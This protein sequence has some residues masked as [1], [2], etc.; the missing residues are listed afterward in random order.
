MRLCAGL[1]V[2]IEGDIHTVT[3]QEELVRWEMGI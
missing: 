3:E 1:E 2:G